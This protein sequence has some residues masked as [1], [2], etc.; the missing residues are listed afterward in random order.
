[1]AQAHVDPEVIRE[2]IARLS[3][4]AKET[5]DKLTALNDYLQSL[6]NSS[7]NDARYHE[8][9]TIFQTLVTNMRANVTGVT[10]EQVPHLDKLA[11]KAED[12]FRN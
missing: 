9:N 10:A 2:F 12:Y 8:Y 4:F 7:W 6:A 5:D 3:Q 1:M 11:T